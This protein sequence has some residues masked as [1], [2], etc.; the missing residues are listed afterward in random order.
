MLPLEG[1]SADSVLFKSTFASN[2]LSGPS[3]DLKY[4]SAKPEKK[5]IVKQFSSS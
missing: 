3:W 5:S 2:S 1:Q 4:E